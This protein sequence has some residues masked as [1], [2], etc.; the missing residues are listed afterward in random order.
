M[1]KDNQQILFLLL[2]I[3]HSTLYLHSFFNTN[4]L[5]QMVC[6]RKEGDGCFVNVQIKIEMSI[7][8]QFIYIKRVNNHLIKDSDHKHEKT[9]TCMYYKV[10]F[11]TKWDFF[12]WSKLKDNSNDFPLQKNNCFITKVSFDYYTLMN[13]E[14]ERDFMLK[15]SPSQPDLMKKNTKKMGVHY[16]NES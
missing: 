2:I 10:V 4:S 12:I 13:E 8:N 16:F 1:S 7:V 3:T 15:I 9:L 5:L 11:P 6:L 14:R